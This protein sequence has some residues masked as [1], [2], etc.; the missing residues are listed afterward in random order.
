MENGEG[1]EQSRSSDTAR[2]NENDENAILTNE[3]G[4]GDDPIRR[5]EST[6]AMAASDLEQRPK[7]FEGR[8]SK[9]SKNDDIITGTDSPNQRNTPEN[10]RS[11][12]G[13]GAVIQSVSGSTKISK[14]DRPNTSS[15]IDQDI[16]HGSRKNCAEEPEDPIET[17]IE[18]VSNPHNQKKVKRMPRYTYKTFNDC[19]CAFCRPKAKRPPNACQ[20]QKDSDNENTDKHSLG[21]KNAQNGEATEENSTDKQPEIEQQER[22]PVVIPR[23]QCEVKVVQVIFRQTLSKTNFEQNQFTWKFQGKGGVSIDSEQAVTE[24]PQNII[25]QRVMDPNAVNKSSMLWRIE[26]SLSSSI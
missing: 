21:D 6:S 18:L 10:Q 2:E 16:N 25:I 24:I 1:I 17:E 5:G 12:S 26:V 9:V 7:S 8:N 20:N 23:A 3:E 4:I 22:K 14:V 19:P 15:P 13:G 11:G